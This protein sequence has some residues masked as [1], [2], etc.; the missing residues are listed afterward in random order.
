MPKLL[1]EK[2]PNKGQSLAL[3]G[4][5]PFHI[6]RE[7]A[8]SF[9]LNDTN[10][11][12]KHCEI[13]S[14]SGNWS[15]RDLGSRNGTYLNGRKLP[16]ESVLQ[17]G[18]RLQTG[19]I[20]IS[21]L[22]EKEGKDKGGLIGTRVGGYRIMERLGRGGMGT[23]YKANQIALNREIALKVLSPD[24]I[25][26]DVFKNLFIA[27][28]RAAAALN[29]PNIVQIHDVGVEGGLHFFSMEIMPNGSVHELLIREGRL[30]P[31]R[32]LRIALD[33]AAGLGYAER[34]GIVHRDIKPEN[35]MIGET[36]VV[37]IGDLGLAFH[38]GQAEVDDEVGVMGTPHFCA[39]EQ[40]TRGKLD[41]R[42][43]LY[44][45][46]ATM[47]RMLAG[48]PPFVGQTLKEILVKKVKEKPM[49]LVEAVKG[50]PPAV[51][52]LVMQ[53]L[54]RNPAD[55]PQSAEEVKG[56]IEAIL[57][58][59]EGHGLAGSGNTTRRDGGGPAYGS[60]AAMKAMSSS[61]PTTI[62]P[63]AASRPAATVAWL[64][65]ATVLL[66]TA[67]A[68]FGYQHF[69]KKDPGGNNSS[70]VNPGP[71][72]EGPV[73]QVPTEQD[74]ANEEQVKIAKWI[75]LTRPPILTKEWANLA[76][77]RFENLVEK[78]PQTP[79]A[80][81]ARLEI[82]KY[83]AQ[84]REIA[85]Q[86]AFQ[87]AQN[88][89]GECEERFKGTLNAADLMPA[90]ERY[91]EVA[92]DY[93]S[94][95]AAVDAGLAAR[96]VRATLA[97]TDE[98]RGEWEKTRAIADGFLKAARFKDSRLELDLFIKRFRDTGYDQLARDQAGR[99]ATAAREHFDTVASAKLNDLVQAKDWDGAKKLV[100][101]LK[102]RYGI[103]DIEM[104]LAETERQ[105]TDL[106]T[107]V[108]PPDTVKS[109]AEIEAEALGV[110]AELEVSWKFAE[111]AMACREAAAKVKAGDA[112]ARLTAAADDADMQEIVRKALKSHANGNDKDDSGL[113]SR[114][115]RGST[116]VSSSETGLML[117]SGQE[118]PWAKI[119]AAEAFKLSLNGWPVSGREAM[120]LALMC[121]RAACWRS[122]R[123]ACAVA[124]HTDRAL[125]GVAKALA[126]RSDREERS[127]IP[128]NA[129][130][131]ELF[132]LEK[133]EKLAAND[134]MDRIVKSMNK[135]KE[136]QGIGE[137]YSG[138]QMYAQSDD[139][140]KQV[141]AGKVD[142]AE[143]E[144]RAELFL[145][146]NACM[147]GNEGEYR[148][149]AFKARNIKP[150]DS[151]SRWVKQADEMWK[152]LVDNLARVDE[153]RISIFA[154]PDP[155]KIGE[156]LKHYE[157]KLHMLVEQRAVAR[158]LTE[159]EDW[160]QDPYV[161]S[162]EPQRILAESCYGMKDF[163]VALKM[164]ERLRS[165]HASH[166][167]C[168]TPENGTSRV[169]REMIDCRARVKKWSLGR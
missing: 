74:L 20:L 85:A 121:M 17:I 134:S 53:L 28:A 78:Y 62:T 22:D 128:I 108:K 29:H 109:D 140:L 42:T 89:E 25:Q 169:D 88:Y 144:W 150:D 162:G 3:S 50:L 155:A 148:A 101:E 138:M 147:Q 80:A 142:D 39:P 132:A 16:G 33:A 65:A 31:A 164:Y 117:D 166:E 35:L 149:H 76:A 72:G 7:P 153:L 24:L 160:R 98:S 82:D 133:A 141:L 130:A 146:L 158:W 113:R 145:A 152:G 129:R 4:S 8:C 1:V 167:W 159:I 100:A 13:V 51:N 70:G 43:D 137:V 87:A 125:S 32:A 47:Y 105:I 41:H 143:E 67:V 111:A 86:E 6:G 15:V 27:E 23:V 79:A 55:R 103:D 157:Q 60:S 26:E 83:R 154:R 38:V 49:P 54:E 46:G 102:G 127:R 36:G 120:G 40:V 91:D 75:S 5:G 66:A 73:G 64:A 116:I 68:F 12:R 94:T 106:S 84:V 114:A 163:F 123:L 21:F 135:A 10:V 63:P 124:G 151:H 122:A 136:T 71:G 44:A 96:R 56:R 99:V 48:K 61:G 131:A 59:I 168:R 11:S 97:S 112:Q 57:P 139:L 81:S 18:D 110:V 92:R 34:K 69:S 165:R 156:L 58:E 104:R 119:T 126:D 52:D 90:A 115:F 2:G 107:V 93:P 14:K 95:E 118:V 161:K 45:L 9:V 30:P 37:K 77:V 19:E